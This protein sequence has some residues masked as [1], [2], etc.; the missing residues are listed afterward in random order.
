MAGRRPSATVAAKSSRATSLNTHTSSTGSRP[1]LMPHQ[2]RQRLIHRPFLTYRVPGK[3]W[4]GVLISDTV[5]VSGHRAYDPSYT[6]DESYL[7]YGKG[8]DAQ[9]D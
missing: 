8:D 2:E 1:P 3:S 7:R 6:E 5:P 4:A 9:G